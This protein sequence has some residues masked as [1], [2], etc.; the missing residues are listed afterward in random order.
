V[1]VVFLNDAWGGSAAT[2]RN[3]YVYGIDV[4]GH[5]FAG[6]SGANSAANG[7]S[8]ADSAILAVNGTLEFNI[9][10]T[11]PPPIMG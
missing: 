10:H 11:A 2:D 4:N 3:L 5:S 8:V 7:T 6:T 1:D 9:N